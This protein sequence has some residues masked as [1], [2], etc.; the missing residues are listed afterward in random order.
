[1]TYAAV[2]KRCMICLRHTYAFHRCFLMRKVVVL[3][4]LVSIRRKWLSRKLVYSRRA[5]FRFMT[6]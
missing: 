5:E 2:S 1:M 4:Y 3:N 6:C